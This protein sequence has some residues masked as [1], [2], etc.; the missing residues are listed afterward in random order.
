M[1]RVAFAAIAVWLV[2]ALP[3]ALVRDAV[4][5]PI[6][7]VAGEGRGVP[8]VVRVERVLPDEAA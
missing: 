7:Q 6:W 3:R 4:V 2:A 8:A 5:V 1:D